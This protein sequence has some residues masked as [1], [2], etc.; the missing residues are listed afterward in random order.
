MS[1]VVGVLVHN[2][3]GDRLN[4]RAAWREGVDFPALPRYLAKVLIL[5]FI[6]PL[7]LNACA[8]KGDFGRPQPTIFD[9]I[10]NELLPS[11]TTL[12]ESRGGSGVTDDEIAMRE[13]GHRLSSP[14]IPAPYRARGAYG[15][16]G[17]GSY[18]ATPA[19]YQNSH[20]LSAIEAELKMDHQALTQF[21]NASRRVLITDS[22]RMQAVDEHDPSLLVNDKRSA[23][24]RMK[25]NLDFIK[26][27]F[28]NF[29]IRLRIFHSSIN[30]AR[31]SSPD[32]FTVELE[33]SLNHLRDRAASL[34]YEL[35]HFFAAAAA[36]GDYLPPRFA[37]KTQQ[38]TGSRMPYPRQAPPQEYIYK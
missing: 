18:G 26:Y 13:A 19:S 30:D 24:E 34:K 11:V 6:L 14:L 25:E 20:P 36:R 5:T 21:G 17:Y 28:E 8:I 7:I 1:R 27:T 23:R 12:L 33:G 4:A 29:D 31:T 38:H 3:P 22:R 16:S 15:T 10:A 32:V 2:T 35:T 37:W 9:R